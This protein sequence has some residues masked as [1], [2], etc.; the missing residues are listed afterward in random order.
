MSFEPLV[1]DVI[2]QQNVSGYLAIYSV[3][4]RLCL[5]FEIDETYF[6]DLHNIHNKMLDPGQFKLFLNTSF[7][8]TS[9]L[10]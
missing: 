1:Q 4:N 10:L 5:Y 9:R 2:C 7:L 6:S 8:I 3:H